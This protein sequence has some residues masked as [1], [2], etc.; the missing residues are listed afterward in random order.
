MIL[1]NFLFKCRLSRA[2]SWSKTK[3]TRTLMNSSG[4]HV[5]AWHNLIIIVVI[6]GQQLK[7]LEYHSFDP[8]S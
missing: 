5:R 1:K 7:G 2:S 4:Y 8:L 6:V 3:L